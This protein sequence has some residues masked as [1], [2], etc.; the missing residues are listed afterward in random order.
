LPFAA[1][2]AAHE[3]VYVED[4]DPEVIRD[5]VAEMFS[6]LDGDLRRDADVADLRV[7][8]DR[9]YQARGHLGMARLAAD[10]LRQHGDFVM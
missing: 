7:R 1:L 5:T 10:F 9:I 8:A 4:N 6:R 2:L 3:G